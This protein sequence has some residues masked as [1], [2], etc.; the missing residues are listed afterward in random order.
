ML[1][2]YEDVVS[3]SKKYSSSLRCISV[4]AEIIAMNAKDFIARVNIY[5]DSWNQMKD[6]AKTKQSYA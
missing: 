6:S 4:K 3:L 5:Q 2:G 1:V